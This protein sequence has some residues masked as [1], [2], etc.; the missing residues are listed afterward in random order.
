MYRSLVLFLALAN[1]IR[2]SIVAS[3]LYFLYRQTIFVPLAR[4]IALS[5]LAYFGGK[6][7]YMSVELFCFKYFLNL[8]N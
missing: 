2:V 8:S 7:K 4:L 3:R 5:P 6:L 1:L